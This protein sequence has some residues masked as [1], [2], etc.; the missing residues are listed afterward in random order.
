M[1]NVTFTDNYGKKTME[2]GPD[3]KQEVYSDWLNSY[4]TI[5]APF[6]NQLQDGSQAAEMCIAKKRKTVS[7][8]MKNQ[9]L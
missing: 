4:L 7:F 2:F 6:L 1:E 3:V 8:H 5:L 9:F